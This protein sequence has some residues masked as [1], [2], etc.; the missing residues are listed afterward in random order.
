MV[1]F[2]RR[3]GLVAIVVGFD[4]YGAASYA[5]LLVDVSKIRTGPPIE[6]DAQSSGGAG[7]RGGRA[8]DDLGI[9]HAGFRR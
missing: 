5:T 4:L 8:E 7:E 1:F 9:G 3:A 6:F 2:D